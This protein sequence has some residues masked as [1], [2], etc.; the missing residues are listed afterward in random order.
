MTRLEAVLPSPPARVLFRR[1]VNDG[2][3]VAHLRRRA[4]DGQSKVRCIR[5]REEIRSSAGAGG[6]HLEGQL[7]GGLGR[8]ALGDVGGS[9]GRDVDGGLL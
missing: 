6:A 1:H 7:I 3:D 5:G 4:T 2:H 9:D 8:V